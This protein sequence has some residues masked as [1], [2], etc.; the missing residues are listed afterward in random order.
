VVI[1]HP[2][3]LFDLRTATPLTKLWYSEQHGHVPPMYL[4]VTRLWGE[5]FGL[6]QRQ[7]AVLS[8]VLSL[9]AIVLLFLAVRELSG[10][11]PALWTA[12]LMSLA[13]PQ[14][15]YA[16]EARNYTLLLLEGL[17]AAAAL[18]RIEKRGSVLAAVVA[19]MVAC[20]L[21]MALTHYFSLGAIAALAVYAA[22]RL[23]GLPLK[24][25][26]RL[27]RRDRRAVGGIG[28]AAGAAA[29]RNRD[30]PR[31][32][33]FLRDDSPGHVARTGV[34]IA[35]LPVRYVAEPMTTSKLFAAAGGVAF[36]LALLLP[37]RRREMLFWSLWLWLTVL[38]VALLGP[39]A[40]HAAPG[41]RPLH[42]PGLSRRFTRSSRR[43]LSE[44][45]TGC[46]HLPPGDG[47]ARVRAAA[48]VRV[49]SVAQA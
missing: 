23:R 38:P 39:D 42:A 49:R 40:W 2:P 10:V 22:V 47:R 6:G 31:A 41:V 28:C 5:P 13:G 30:D 32:T 45:R 29:V 15:Q 11:T 21:A 44:R 34:R 17:G 8:V 9:G 25:V 3:D 26:P 24:R 33:A 1:E 20:A 12:L 35:A 14:I 4:L 16:Q 18:V 19:A 7:R 37:L 27:L 48:A 43:W 46:V 36:V